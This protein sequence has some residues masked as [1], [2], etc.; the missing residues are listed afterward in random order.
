MD[1]AIWENYSRVVMETLELIA[2]ALFGLNLLHHEMNRVTS[3]L[4]KCTW[5][6]LLKS[7]ES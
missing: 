5:I 1:R 7:G 2:S 6:V 3:S 4:F